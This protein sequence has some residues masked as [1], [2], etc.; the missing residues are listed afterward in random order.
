[1]GIQVSKFL[2]EKRNFPFLSYL[3]YDVCTL[4]VGREQ[5]KYILKDKQLDAAL[6]MLGIRMKCL[7]CSKLC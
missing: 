5:E 6:L 1:M 4:F 3:I 7:F 2:Y